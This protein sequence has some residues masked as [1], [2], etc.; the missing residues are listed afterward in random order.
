MGD[1]EFAEKFA[2]ADDR[3]EVLTQLIPGT[4]EHFHASCLVAEQNGQLDRVRELV[5]AWQERH[6]ETTRVVEMKN[7]LAL[8]AFVDDATARE[9]LRRELGVTFDHQREAER[10]ATAHPSVLD[11]GKIS[12]ETVGKN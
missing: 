8:H 6:G 9:H 2:L 7:R 10:H 1:I 4:D 5:G 12:V 3:A 11:A